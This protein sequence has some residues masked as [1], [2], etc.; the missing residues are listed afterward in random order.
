MF[1]QE[2]TDEEGDV[3][4]SLPQGWNGKSKNV[5]AIIKIVPE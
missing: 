3:L 4:S 5:Q 1:L 2:M